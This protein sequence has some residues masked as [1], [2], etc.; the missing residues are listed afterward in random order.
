MIGFINGRFDE[1][2]ETGAPFEIAVNDGVT[3]S[4]EVFEFRAL[5]GGARGVGTGF[6][7]GDFLVS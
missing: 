6:I 4:E 2:F 5:Y 7:G 3:K 1:E